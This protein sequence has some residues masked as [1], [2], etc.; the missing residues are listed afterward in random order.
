[1]RALPAVPRR[2]LQPLRGRPLLR[3]PPIDGAFCNYVTIHE[4]FAF[5]LSDSV[6]DDAGAMMEPLSVGVWAC[7][8]AH[9]QGGEHVLVTGAGPIGLLAMQAALAHGA[10]A[11]TVADVSPTGWS[12][13]AGPATR[14][15]KFT[16]ASVTTADRPAATPRSGPSATAG[17]PSA[18]E[19]GWTAHVNATTDERVPV[20]R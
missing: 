3:H 12:W 18:R 11:V 14:S 19:I 13:P 4:D 5:P 10:T 8:K 6:S 16:P 17:I 7:R 20:P 2:P 1:M 15:A 9:L